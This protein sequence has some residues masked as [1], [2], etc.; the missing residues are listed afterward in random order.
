MWLVTGMQRPVVALARS[1]PVGRYGAGGDPSTVRRPGEP[2]PGPRAGPARQPH[3]GCPRRGPRGRVCHLRIDDG[4]ARPTVTVGT[5]TPRHNNN[6]LPNLYSCVAPVH[7]FCCKKKR[8]DALL[9]VNGN[10]SYMDVAGG[11]TRSARFCRPFHC[12]SLNDDPRH[13]SLFLLTRLTPP[14]P[15]PRLNA[16]LPRLNAPPPRL[17]APPPC[18]NVPPPRVN[19]PPLCFR[20]GPCA[21]QRC[22]QSRPGSR[23]GR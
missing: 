3:Q 10:P 18:V 7:P 1:R 23:G 5:N 17:N 11:R 20:A 12:V 9:Y 16:P 4:T 2:A 22:A 6:D 15:P 21:A 13:S 19:T 14:H 8:R